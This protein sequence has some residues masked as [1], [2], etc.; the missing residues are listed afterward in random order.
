RSLGR[1]LRVSFGQGQFDRLMMYFKLAPLIGE[2]DTL[3]DIANSL[4]EHIQERGRADELVR[5]L[6]DASASDDVEPINR[7]WAYDT[8]TFWQMW[9]RDL[10]RVAARISHLADLLRAVGAAPI[11]AKRSLLLKQM[12]LAG[13][14]TDAEAVRRCYRELAQIPGASDEMIRVQ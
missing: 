14:R 10:N 4:S 9:D 2:S 8:A 5:I 11:N 3:V 12:M 13:R 1:L 6:E 7:F